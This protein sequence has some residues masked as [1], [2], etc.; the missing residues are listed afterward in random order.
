MK[1]ISFLILL[2]RKPFLTNAFS[3]AFINFTRFNSPLP[4]NSVRA[5]A[6]DSQGRK[7]FG[8]DYGMAIY[9]DTTWTVYTTVNSGIS[10]NSI[11]HIS[12][13]GADNAW[14]CT[15]LGG[16]NKFDG[17]TFTVFNTSNSG[18]ASNYVRGIAIDSNDVKWI[19]TDNGFN[20]F[21]AHTGIFPID[22][23]QSIVWVALLPKATASVILER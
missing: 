11:K 16:I 15:Q 10:D 3:Q 14:I 7:W 17:T 21:T 20:R 23:Y 1:R 19:C 22:H 9:N 12:F 18:I 4:D 2:S 13:D 8:T 5:I 6:V